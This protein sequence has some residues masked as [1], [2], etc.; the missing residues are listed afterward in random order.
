MLLFG[1]GFWYLSEQHKPGALHGFRWYHF[2]LLATTYSLFFIIFS[3][4]VVRGEVP[5]IPA[6]LISSAG[7]LPL[8][9]LH[10]SRIIDR[11]FAVMHVLPM[12]VLTLGI[13]IAGVYGGGARDYIFIGYLVTGVAYMTF[14][15]RPP[16]KPTPPMPQLT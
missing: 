7:S 12:A 5:V 16:E 10:V 11:H 9:V 14:T 4:I 8:L 3:V 1:A 6:I 15:S 13:V 2:L